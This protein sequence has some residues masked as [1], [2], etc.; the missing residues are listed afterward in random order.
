MIVGGLLLM[1]G[2]H[3]ATHSGHRAGRA[4]F[5]LIGFFMFMTLPLISTLVTDIL[6]R[7]LAVPAI[8]LIGGVGNLFGGFVGPLLIGCLKQT[9][10]GFSLAFG[11]LGLFGVIG[12]LLV[13]GVRARGSQSLGS[14][15][16]D[17]PKRSP[18]R[19]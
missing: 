13:L 1:W 14:Q 8:G 11:L 3:V 10:G 19:H 15:R 6:P 12:G 7:P 4:S 18:A 5:T 16:G 2:S 17:L 9:T